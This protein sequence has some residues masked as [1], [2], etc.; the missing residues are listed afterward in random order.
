MKQFDRVRFV[1]GGIDISNETVELRVGDIGYII[2]DYA[3]GFYEVEFMNDDG[4]TRVQAVLAKHMM[5]VAPIAGRIAIT[6]GG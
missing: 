4:S 2:E 1:G 3:D 5:E 6:P